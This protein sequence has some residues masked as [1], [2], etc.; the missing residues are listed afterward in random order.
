MNNQEL[1]QALEEFLSSKSKLVQYVK[2]R[3]SYLA[4][5]ERSKGRGGWL[6]MDESG[7]V[8]RFSEK[9]K[10]GIGLWNPDGSDD[11]MTHVKDAVDA[12]IADATWQHTLTRI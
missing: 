1:G 7:G 6:A 4:D 11:S 3:M 10:M 2:E 9:P 5:A 12:Q 8:Y